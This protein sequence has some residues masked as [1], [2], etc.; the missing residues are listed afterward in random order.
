MSTTPSILQ[1][2]Q[3]RLAPQLAEQRRRALFESNVFARV[4]RQALRRHGIL[5]R[6]T[7]PGTRKHRELGTYYAVNYESGFV[8]AS[9][10]RLE[11]VALELEVI[12]PGQQIVPG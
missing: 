12:R 6:K 2:I 9:H 1:S 10:V 4:R 11:D 5:L 3:A 8:E 7:K